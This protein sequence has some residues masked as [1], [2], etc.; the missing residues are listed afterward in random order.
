M[1]QTMITSSSKWNLFHLLRGH[2]LGNIQNLYHIPGKTEQ[3]ATQGAF[4]GNIMIEFT[5]NIV[6]TKR[7][8]D[9]WTLFSVIS[10]L[11]SFIRT[12][13]FLF[14]FIFIFFFCPKKPLCQTRRCYASTRQ[15][16]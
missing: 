5:S 11:Q 1:F 10:R 7:V 3:T 12:N 13:T 2:R 14:Y 8:K 6:C 9:L 15:L 16:R 4:T